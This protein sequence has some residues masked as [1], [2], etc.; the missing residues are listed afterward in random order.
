MSDD[1][2]LADARV[3]SDAGHHVYV[4]GAV[5]KRITL[6]SQQI[7]A[8]N[9]AGALSRS[10]D[11]KDKDIDIAVIGAGAAGLTAAASMALLMPRAKIAVF[12]REAHALHLQHGCTKRFLHP[13]I[14]DWPDARSKTEHT[15][16]PILNWSAATSDAVAKEIGEAFGSIEA[17]RSTHLR[18]HRNAAVTNLESTGR[19]HRLSFKGDIPGYG[20]SYAFHAVI[21]A[22]GFGPERNLFF[23]SHSYW[24]DQGVPSASKVRPESRILVSGSGDGGLIDL[25]A[26]SVIGFNHSDFMTSV[27]AHSGIERIE[28]LLLGIEAEAR[29]VDGYDYFAAY[30]D[31]IGEQAEKDGLVA[32]LKAS[33]RRDVS[34]VFNTESKFPFD[35]RASILSR[36]LA[37]LVIKAAPTSISHVPGELSCADGFHFK[38]DGAD[39]PV[40]EAYIR[41]GPDKALLFAPFAAVLDAYKTVQLGRPAHEA[42][43]PLRLDS[44]TV[45]ALRDTQ[46]KYSGGR[47]AES[48]QFV[49]D[50]TPDTLP[51]RLREPQLPASFRGKEIAQVADFFATTLSSGSLTTIIGPAMSGRST[52]MAMVSNALLESGHDRQ[53]PLAVLQV[54][55]SDTLWS[56]MRPLYKAVCGDRRDAPDMI[57]D[58]LADDSEDEDGSSPIWSMDAVRNFTAKSISGRL[59]ARKLVAVFENISDIDKK[60][61]GEIQ[62]ILA[63]PA[64]S[65]A[66]TLVES[67]SP[68]PA[69]AVLRSDLFLESLAPDV[70]RRFLVS[71][72]LTEEK[73]KGTIDAL[74]GMSAT[75]S[76]FEPYLLVPI[77]QYYS[78]LDDT[79]VDDLWQAFADGAERAATNSINRLAGFDDAR[80]DMILVC[81]S[82]LAIFR[83]SAKPSAL[84]S[85]IGLPDLPFDSLVAYG[86]LQRDGHISGFGRSALLLI[87]PKMLAPEN[88]NQQALADLIRKLGTALVNNKPPEAQALLDAPLAWLMRYAPGQTGL[89]EDLGRLLRQESI[90]DEVPPNTPAATQEALEHDAAL[91]RSGELEPALAAIATYVA[92]SYALADPDT[93]KDF[94]AVA[95]SIAKILTDGQPINARQLRV[96]DAALYYGARRYHAFGEILAVMA[97]C[98]PALKAQASTEDDGWKLAWLSFLINLGDL[99][100][101]RGRLEGVDEIVKAAEGLLGPD[102][103]IAA[104]S[105]IHW[106]RARF[107][108]LRERLA[109][110][111]A[112][113]I[114]ALKDCVA[115]ASA[116]LSA[117]PDDPGRVRFF[118]RS[119]RRLAEVERDDDARKWIIDDAI[120]FLEQLLGAHESWDIAIRAQVAALMRFEARRAWDL[121]Y[122]KKRIGQ[123]L[124]L[125]KSAA[126]ADRAAWDDDPRACLVAA[127][128]EAFLGHSRVARHDCLRSLKLAPSPAAWSLALR[129]TY[130]AEDRNE[131]QYEVERGSNEEP[132]EFTGL[133]RQFR[134]GLRKGEFTELGYGHVQLLIVQQE[135]KAQGSIER[136]AYNQYEQNG[137]DF[138]H[139][140]QAVRLHTLREIYNART[141]QLNAI[142]NRFGPF[143]SLTSARFRHEAQYQRTMAIR[144]NRALDMAP[145]M[146]IL[147]RAFQLWPDA[148]ILEYLRAEYFRYVW[149]LTK[150]IEGFRHVSRSATSG[151]LRR[152]ASL[153]LARTLHSAAVFGDDQEEGAA[154]RKLAQLNEAH[155]IVKDLLGNRDIGVEVAALKDHIALE[156]GETIDWVSLD[157]KYGQIVG[158]IHGFPNALIEHFGEF[159][160]LD[161]R[162]ENL[163]QVLNT[164]FADSEAL[165][166]TGLLYLR[167]AEKGLGNE[168]PDYLAKALGCLLAQSIIERSWR[169]TELPTTSF[170]IARTIMAAVKA[171]GSLNP[172]SAKLGR[173][174]QTQLDAAISRL[175]SVTSRTTGDFC[176]IAKLNRSAAR[177]LQKEVLAAKAVD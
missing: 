107:A 127:R 135:W 40:D 70:A 6:Y 91:G 168:N 71:Q 18:L 163:A 157:E 2:I 146:A 58:S 55:F 69:P 5:D 123:A 45:T 46:D 29:G 174:G 84:N 114:A 176:A 159:S 95:Q 136:V 171:T 42:L 7:R 13:S 76:F 49:L 129:L 96:F 75:D 158:S 173:D 154:D 56:P 43:S 9:L 23:R 24:T 79:S 62:H 61:A 19:S 130:D 44:R 4:I 63:A 36:F 177:E 83:H 145:I 11:L 67:A 143:V 39:V 152:R 122:Q 90:L 82:A 77:L 25:V 64:I 166:L 54:N 88:R 150:A 35:G 20:R 10:R 149:K 65:N 47:P 66:F 160:R 105:S 175:D 57:D 144:N 115:H 147:D 124:E 120:C 48:R 52:L 94:V 170:R 131:E 34:I 98:F 8:M 26:A 108:C 16:L 103:T 142:E 148:H 151:D 37:Y 80:R 110:D 93:R 169:G 22:I 32:K 1:D 21:F 137:Q 156:I 167:R 141:R 162:P 38:I 139:L 31:R 17:R 118:L 126:A 86:W 106:L 50:P 12:E 53:Q 60:Y 78:K 68:L 100:V 111:N 41:H 140:P 155:A 161:H 134:E 27:I 153:S 73:A 14:F 172:F 81:L 15:V 74:T 138:A 104:N 102:Q 109:P 99:T 101:S 97:A 92:P 85:A 33:L 119:L 89:I 30:E 112:Q 121:P 165:G 128:L 3:S 51:P 117:R 116:S 28:K 87:A 113:R 125:L 72:K 59:G 164:Q 133:K 132:S